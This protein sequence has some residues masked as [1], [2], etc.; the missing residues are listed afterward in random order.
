MFLRGLQEFRAKGDKPI[1]EAAAKKYLDKISVGSLQGVARR[2]MMDILKS[3]TNELPMGGS[4]KGER[5]RKPTKG[6]QKKASS[7]AKSKRAPKKTASKA[8]RRPVVKKKKARRR[9]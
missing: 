1:D 6:K 3:P 7:K 9:N 4:D 5:K 2:I 8:S